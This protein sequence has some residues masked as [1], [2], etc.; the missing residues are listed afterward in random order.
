MKVKKYLTTDELIATIKNKGITIL[1]EEQS[2]EILKQHNYYVIMGYKNLFIKDNKY[3]NNVSFE[4]IYSLYKFDRQLKILLL[5]ALLDIESIVKNAI[6]NYFCNTYGYKE[7]DYLKKDNYNISHKYLNKTMAIFK[8]QIDDKKNTNIAVDY[9]IKTYN[10]V[11]LWVICK[12]ISFGLVKELYAIMKKED[13]TIIKDSIC[14]FDDTKIKHLYL[15]LQLIV[16][17]RNKIAHDDILFNDIHR[18]IILHK[19][20]EHNKFNLSGNSGLNDTLGLLISI[21]NILPKQDFNKLIDDLTILIDNYIKNNNVIT[22]EEL[23]KE[24]HL[25]LNYEILKW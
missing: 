17:K 1:D 19:T 24:M 12:V 13:E 25:P 21:K 14:N 6:V 2:K 8:Q 9:Y 11:P 3:K 5:N 15:Q 10:F 20:K 4:N 18:R 16:D 23:L 7:E 22:K